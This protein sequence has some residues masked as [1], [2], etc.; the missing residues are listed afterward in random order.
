M[1]AHRDRLVHIADDGHIG[2]LLAA[3]LDVP[4]ISF[5]GLFGPCSHNKSGYGV[6]VAIFSACWM[7]EIEFRR[8]LSRSFAAH[9]D[10]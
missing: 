7:K 6:R 4:E 10:S 8:R 2:S 9:P 5:T 1:R 3:S